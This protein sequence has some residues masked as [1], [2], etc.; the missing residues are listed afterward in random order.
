ME[1]ACSLEQHFWVCCRLT[2]E[3]A[4]RWAGILLFILAAVVSLTAIVTLTRGNRPEASHIGVGITVVALVVMPSLAWLKRKIAR[5]TD[6]VAL[7]A[8]AV[9]SATCAYLAAITLVGLV[10]NALFHIH[11][12][13]PVAALA[14]IPILL[15]EGRRALRG[16][17]CGCR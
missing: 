14:A 6:N 12:M 9:Q 17:S 2:K 11:W 5:E 1:G 16:E 15:I 3:R 4:A 8:N 13:D 7:A 10:A